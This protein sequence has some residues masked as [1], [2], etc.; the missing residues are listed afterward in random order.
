[1]ALGNI[2]NARQDGHSSVGADVFCILSSYIVALRDLYSHERHSWMQ[3][4]YG[5]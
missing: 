5:V 4:R 2:A 1:M 3:M